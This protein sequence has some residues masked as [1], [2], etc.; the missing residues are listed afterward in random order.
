M[1]NLVVTLWNKAPAP[2]PGFSCVVSASQP[3]ES[4]DTHRNA[5]NLGDMPRCPSHKDLCYLDTDVDTHRG[6]RRSSRASSST[7]GMARGPVC[8]CSPSC[9]FLFS[10]WCRRSYRFSHTCRHGNCNHSLCPRI[11][12]SLSALPSFLPISASHL[13]YRC[14]PPPNVAS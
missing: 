4:P 2:Y 13:G 9:L 6:G 11:L 7:L 3:L 8:A 14:C 10:T 1:V 5:R 12:L